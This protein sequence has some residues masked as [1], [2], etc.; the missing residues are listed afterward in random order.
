MALIPDPRTDGRNGR[1]TVYGELQEQ[2]LVADYRL[3]TALVGPEGV[4]VRICVGNANLLNFSI[5]PDPR[6]KEDDVLCGVARSF[7]VSKVHTEHGFHFVCDEGNRNVAAVLLEGLNENSKSALIDNPDEV[8]AL[9]D[10]YEVYKAEKVVAEAS[11][12]G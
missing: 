6:N 11:R 7:G 4:F 8:V 10:L 5:Q 9:C 1:R 2:A 12:R 3:R